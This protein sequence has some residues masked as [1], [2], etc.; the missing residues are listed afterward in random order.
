MGIIEIILL[1]VGL[2]MD[3]FAVS[4]CKGLAM[5]KI[6]FK[7]AAVC[8]VWF[9]GFQAL[10]PMIGYLLG[11]FSGVDADDRLSAGGTVCALYYGNYT[12]DCVCIT[13]AHRRQ[14]DP[15]GLFEM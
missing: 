6:N 10:M 12:L 11:G 15:R 9:G 2:S 14:Y 3:A 1:A 5:P 7:N 4:I 8:G 13:L